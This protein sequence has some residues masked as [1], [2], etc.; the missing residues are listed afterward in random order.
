MRH[1]D[2]NAEK[3]APEKNTQEVRERK[4]S[5][6]RSLKS[7]KSRVVVTKTRKTSGTKIPPK[8][9]AGVATIG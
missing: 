1:A 5:L 7:M 8:H 3:R 2:T 4:T 6:E 9:R